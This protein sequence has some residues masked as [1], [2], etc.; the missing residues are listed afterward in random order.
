MSVVIIDY[1]SGN[2]HSAEKSFAR[3]AGPLGIDTIVSADPEAVRRAERVMLPGVGAYGD[4]AAGLA[5]VPGLRE[6][7]IERVID[8]GA[9]FLGVCV[10][11]QLMTEIGRERG[12]Y[13][14][15]GW[16][17]GEVVHLTPDD[18]D[19]KIPHMGWNALTDLAAH[20]LWDGIAPG[21]HGYFV[22]SY[23]ALPRDPAHI[24]ATAEYGGPLTAAIGRDNLFGVQ[25][26]PEKSQKVGLQLIDNFLRWR[27]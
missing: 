24:L 23:H 15:L 12:E 16:V 19:L 10:G 11:M 7:L 2:L 26:H 9:P 5:A 3:M 13:Q 21:G 4:C 8:G 6:A 20:P 14:G 17:P 22:H 18:P 1:G 25:F 27:P